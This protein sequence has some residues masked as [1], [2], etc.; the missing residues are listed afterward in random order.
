MLA[1]LAHADPV[2]H[3]AFVIGRISRMTPLPADPAGAYLVG[4]AAAAVW[5]YDLSLGF[6]DTAVSGLRAQGRLGL[7]AQALVS[8]AWVAVH[9]AREPLA[10]SA[11]EE[12]A[13]LAHE[14][15][16]LRRPLSPQSGETSLPPTNWQAKPKRCSCRW[17]RPRCWPWWSLSGA[18]VP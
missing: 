6:L 4:S 10:V 15:R 17:V 7:L 14:T 2:A 8:Q 9:L 3:G 13:R 1:I 16:S 11:A 12:A 18:A 5:A